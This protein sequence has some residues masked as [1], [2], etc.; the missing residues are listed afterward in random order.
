MF[1][2]EEY[3]YTQNELGEWVPGEGSEEV[4]PTQG[5][6]ATQPTTAQPTNVPSQPNS[7]TLPASLAPTDSAASSS[8]VLKGLSSLS[9]GIMGAAKGAATSAA[10]AVDSKAVADPVADPTTHLPQK[11]QQQANGYISNLQ[12]TTTNGTISH[13]FHEAGSTNGSSV[14]ALPPRPVDYDDYWYQ[15]R[16]ILHQLTYK[17]PH[18]RKHISVVSG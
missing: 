7:Q 9:S 1:R 11:D 16:N 4:P 6:P 15:G 13:D 14:T 5:L 10:Q 2:L 12:N 17:K 8:N 3:G 18:N